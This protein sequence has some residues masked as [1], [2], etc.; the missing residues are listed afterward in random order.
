MDALKGR[1]NEEEGCDSFW[2]RAVRHHEYGDRPSLGAAPC[3]MMLPS[4]LVKSHAWQPLP[5]T[6]EPSL[7]QYRVPECTMYVSRTSFNG[8]IWKDP[9]RY[10]K[11]RLES[12]MACWRE[13]Y[14]GCGRGVG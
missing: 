11:K 9:M 7:Q 4:L 8:V 12:L 6:T 5:D 10:W 14:V 2:F 1:E 13:V 3:K